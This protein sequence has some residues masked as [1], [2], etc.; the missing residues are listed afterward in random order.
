[1]LTQH[2]ALWKSVLAW[3]LELLRWKRR[4]PVGRRIPCGGDAGAGRSGDAGLVTPQRGGLGAG[5]LSPSPPPYLGQDIGA[6][7]VTPCPFA[8]LI[9][10]R[11]ALPWLKPLGLE[12][13]TLR[14]LLRAAE[15]LG[16]ALT[17]EQPL[18][19]SF[20]LDLPSLTAA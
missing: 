11:V 5:E 7:R 14:D 9:V 19:L 8:K 6:P 13:G 16:V 17:S 20:S 2:A 10:R 3:E 15:L 18:T 12:R 4:L 1:M